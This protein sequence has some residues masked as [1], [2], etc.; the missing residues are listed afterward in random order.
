MMPSRVWLVV[1]ALSGARAAAAQT[2]PLSSA[3]VADSAAL[4]GSAPRLAAAVLATYTDT[5]RARYLDNLFHLQLLTGKYRDASATITQW[6]ALGMPR[7]RYVQLEIF[8]RAKTLADSGGRPFT[9]AFATAF[10]ETFARLDDRSAAFATRAIL[11]PPRTVANDL[12]WATPDQT[13]KTT[14]SLDD[15]LTLLHVYGAVDAYRG[16]AGLAT[17]LVAEDD[18][19][20]Y[21]IEPSVA[22]K[23]PDG[24][25][26]CAIIV[27]P[28]AAP[29][30]RPA[31]LQF[32]IYADS[33]IGMRDA[34]MAAANGYAGVTGFTRGKACSPDTIVPYVYDGADAAALI[35]WIAAQP[36]SD[37][38]VG[39]YGGS[40]SGFTVWAA[41]KH[42]PPALKAMMVGA[43]VAPGIDVPMEGNVFWNFVYPWPFYTMNNRWLDNA[44][45]FQNGR[46]NR[47]NREWYTSGRPY[48]QL[49]QIDGTPNPG[50]AAWLAHPTLDAYWRGVIPQ[51]AEYAKITIPVL[52]TAG[53]FYGG[54]G[55]AIYYFL[56]HYRHNPRANHYLLIGPYDHVQAQRGV[57][58]PLGDTATFYAGYVID[59]VARIDIVADLRYQWF[60]Y[61]LRGGPK[62]ALLQ[63]RVNYEVMGANV[64]H[65][66]PSIAAAANGRLR[67]YFS[68]PR[69]L[70]ER[71]PPGANQPIVQT[72]NLA[73]RSDVDARGVGGL[74]STEID[75]SN[76]FALVGDPLE[77]SVEVSGLLSGH[78]ELIA[79]KR[80]FDFTITPYEL[81]ADGQYFQMSPYTSRASHVASL[82]ERRLLTPGRVEHLD[83]ASQLRM[84][85][86]R[87]VAGS[88]LVIVVS[89][90]KNQGQQI[91]YG[92]G[93]NVSDE[94]VADAGE[95]LTIRWLPGS[96]V[97]LPMRR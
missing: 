95:P 16:F 23:T 33:V 47:L 12:R 91:N 63:D 27:R 46:W 83:F 67:L 58:T 11:L 48:R 35:G 24:A 79:N 69:G 19:R 37:G 40:Y 5:N 51:G 62:P 59:P 28:R 6:R 96:Y 49:E 8:A 60:D 21:S 77:R 2:F 7:D 65:H 45:Y 22:V 73:D 82:T 31:L 89:I 81:M 78:L 3:D 29:E 9:E 32:T 87:V 74:L 54:P 18:A 94:S 88:R 42:M 34:L 4:A 86:R 71:P 70:S 41:A 39:M 66:A 84:T 64:W 53:Y 76:G 14:V 93:K 1:L 72:V 38:R 56:E 36:W 25:T 44:T 68:A 85:S 43:P 26:V 50:Y 30:R 52:Q 75:S 17:P 97:Q 20:R 90:V 92:T 13:G 10:R 55:A 80:D 57:I 15:A 61:A